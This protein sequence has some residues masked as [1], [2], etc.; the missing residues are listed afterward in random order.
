MADTARALPAQRAKT[1]I[2][3]LLTI[4]IQAAFLRRRPF[5][6]PVEPDRLERRLRVDAMDAG[7]GLAV[8]LQEVVTGS[9]RL[10]RPQ[11][12]SA[13]RSNHWRYRRARFRGATAPPARAIMTSVDLTIA[14]ASSPRRS[15]SARTASAVITAV[16]D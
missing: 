8:V 5:E 15:L 13:E 14:S 7:H 11:D 3:L 16:K 2:L 1:D 10:D 9:G 6:D 4:R 12:G